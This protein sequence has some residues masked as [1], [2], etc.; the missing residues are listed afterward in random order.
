[1]FKQFAELR[2]VRVLPA[3]VILVFCL[4]LSARSRFLGHELAQLSEL[5]LAILPLVSGANPR[6]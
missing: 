3:G 4:Q 5:I 6:I 1:M 2:T